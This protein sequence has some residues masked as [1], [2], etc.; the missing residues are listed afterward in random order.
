MSTV[1]GRRAGPYV[2]GQS[3]NGDENS[4]SD[5]VTGTGPVLFDTGPRA[6]TCQVCGADIPPDAWTVVFDYLNLTSELRRGRPLCWPCA[7]GHSC[8]QWLLPWRRYGARL[9]GREQDEY[10]HRCR[11]CQRMFIGPIQRRY[12]S[13]ECGEATR[14][15]RRDRTRDRTARPCD[16]CGDTFTPPRSDGRYCSGAC[17]QRAYRRRGGAS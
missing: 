10:M 8:A 15:G 16:V 17:R 3:R 9:A 14:A 2:P 5:T 4:R 13:Y 6:V 12:C 11:Q 7:V 1:T